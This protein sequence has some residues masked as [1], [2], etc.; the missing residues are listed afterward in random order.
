MIL[1]FNYKLQRGQAISPQLHS[2]YVM[3]VKP[4]FGSKPRVLSCT[5]AQGVSD[6]EI[7]AQ[8]G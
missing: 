1:S 3:K 8:R 6:G 5:P 2:K 7:E 4:D